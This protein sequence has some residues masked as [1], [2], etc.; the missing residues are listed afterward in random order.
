MPHA[1]T[2][3]HLTEQPAIG[4]FA[5]LGWTT[6]SALQTCCGRGCCRGR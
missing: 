4:S 1:Y 2:E 5:E 3:D 6:L